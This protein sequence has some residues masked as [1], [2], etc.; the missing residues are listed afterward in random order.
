MHAQT[1]KQSPVKLKRPLT[2][3]QEEVLHFITRYVDQKKDFPSFRTIQDELG[4]AS[5]NSITQYM[6]A[7]VRKGY[8]V[9]HGDQYEFAGDNYYLSPQRKEELQ[10]TM[11][12]LLGRL[13]SYMR[14][15]GTDEALISLTKRQYRDTFDQ[16]LRG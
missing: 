15:S 2:E 12:S 3:K 14:R 11:Q 1:Q 6:K 10:Q 16:L 4:Y 9:Q 8:L 7:L 13:D 5:P